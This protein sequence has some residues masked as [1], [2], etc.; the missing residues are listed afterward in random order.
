[1][2]D[3][4]SGQLVVV[5]AGNT[6][7]VFGIFRGGELATDF[8]LSTDPERTADEYTALLSPLFSAAGLDPRQTDALLV[9]SVVPRLRQILE[10][11]GRR[12]FAAD[13][14]FVGPALDT[15]LEIRHLDPAEVGADRVVN[16]LAARNLYGAPLVVVDFGTATTFDVLAPD[17]AYVGGLIAPGPEISAEALFSHASRLYRVDLRKPQRL[18]G[19]D[20][21]GAMRS[22]IYYGY[23]GLVDG[24]LERLLAEL[25]ELRTVV[26]TGGQARWIAE[27][28]RFIRHVEPLLTLYGLRQI[29]EYQHEQRAARD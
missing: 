13:P 11:L 25:G 20:T 1:M 24:I 27:G 14:V 5:D 16:S 21:A 6:N 22:G 2:A 7:T 3:S 18:I 10:R 15:G 23:L 17:G 12:Y 4:R 26:A 29:H 28:S 9:S 8:R 19:R